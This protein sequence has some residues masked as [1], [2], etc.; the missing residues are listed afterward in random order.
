M[1]DT[2]TELIHFLLQLHQAI[3]NATCFCTTTVSEKS[4]FLRPIV[5]G[6]MLRSARLFE[7]SRRPSSRYLSRYSVETLHNM[8]LFQEAYSVAHLNVLSNVKIHPSEALK[9]VH[10]LFFGFRGS[11]KRTVSPIETAYHNMLL[12][13][14]HGNWIVCLWVGF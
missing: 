9:A 14:L 5:K 12:P 3:I 8:R 7:I 10:A 1:T 13:L 4:Q 11:S 2:Q 6:L